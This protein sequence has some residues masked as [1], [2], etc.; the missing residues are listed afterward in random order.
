MSSAQTLRE[1]ISDLFIFG[2]GQQP[3][4]LAGS[5]DPNNPASLQA[6][7]SHF[8]PASS[9]ENSALIAFLTDALG[10]SIGGIPIGSTS[11]GETFR[12]E[13]GLPVLV[14]TSSGPNF[15]ERAQP[16]GWRPIAPGITRGRV[17]LGPGREGQM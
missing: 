6:H 14:S 7:G 16:P 3:L 8:I 1:R 10:T 17:A 15:A 2:P 5:G 13:A 4:F 11:G 12:F 9:A